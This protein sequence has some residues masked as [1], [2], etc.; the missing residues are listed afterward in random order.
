MKEYKTIKV[1]EREDGISIIKFN[2][3]ESLNAISFELTEEMLDYLKSIENNL[4]IRVL[5]LTGEGRG[6]SSGLDLKESQIALKPLKKI[7]EEYHR[8]EYLLTKD[9]VKRSILAQKMLSEVMILLRKIPQP[10]IA[11]VNGVAYGGGLGFALAADIRLAGDSAKFCNAFINIGV[12]GADMGSSYWLP[13]LIGFSRAAEFMYT[14]RVMDAKE[15]DKIGLVT[16][17]V[18]D[19][20]LLEEATNL[21]QQILGKSPMGIR[22]TKDA[23][24]ANIDAQSLEVAIKLEN[25]SQVICLSTK[26][27]LEGVFSFLEKREP[28]YDKW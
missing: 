20:T 17:V 24:N 10:V 11:A 25:R 9:K 28:N 16:R 13:R 27:L 21:A 2:R 14:G 15:A 22:F 12:S 26:D 8:F 18:A 5:I 19:E 6:F 3:P 4:A 7:P 1:E 23:L